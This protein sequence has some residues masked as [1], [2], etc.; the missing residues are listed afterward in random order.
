MNYK[1]VI[2][3]LGLFINNLIWHAGDILFP[4][5]CIFCGK[6][7][8]ERKDI[9]ACGKCEKDL[10]PD[11]DGICYEARGKNAE[12]IISPFIYED[13]VRKAIISFKFSD[14]EF[15][16][17]TLAHFMNK[18][19]ENV[20]EYENFDY[21]IPVPMYKTNL[22]KRGY[23]QAGVLAENIEVKGAEYD[24]DN[25]I[26]IKDNGAQSMRNAIERADALKECFACV[27]GVEDKNILLVDDI[28]T[29]GVTINRCA[30]ELKKMGASRVVGLTCAKRNTESGAYK[31]WNYILPR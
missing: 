1:R 16:G 17:K 30:L 10:A 23:N 31:K 4:R 18:A 20:Y 6:V 15:Y 27:Y 28:C 3:K 5:K 26:R 8:E 25:L 24:A 14:K 12:Y 9:F 11:K 2:D 21:I 7:I 22:K 19:M 29:T 13:S